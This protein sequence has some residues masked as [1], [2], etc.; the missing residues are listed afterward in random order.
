MIL[1][2]LKF[3]LSIDSKIFFLEIKSKLTVD[4][5]GIIKEPSLT[6]LLKVSLL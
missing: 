4:A 2:S 6:N 3:A 5:P 1:I